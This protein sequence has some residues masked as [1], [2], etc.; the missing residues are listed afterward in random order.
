[1]NISS[2]PNESHPITTPVIC[3]TFPLLVFNVSCTVNFEGFK[4][5][6]RTKLQYMSVRLFGSGLGEVLKFNM[7]Q[8]ASSK[9]ILI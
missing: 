4:S 2:Q 6:Q 9:Q 5:S 8:R 1:M 3:Y 7:R